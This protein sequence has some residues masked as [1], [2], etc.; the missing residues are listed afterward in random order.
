MAAYRFLDN[1]RVT[2]KALM[3][4][5]KDQCELR[6]KGREIL[7]LCDTSAINVESR[8]NRIEDASGLGPIEKTPN[9]TTLGFFIHPVLAIDKHDNTVYGIAAM[10]IWNRAE[11][12][13]RS[14]KFRYKSQ[15][16][17]IEIKESMK[18]LRPCQQS[19]NSSLSKAKHV[20]YVMDREGDIIEVF[21]R[22][23]NEKVDLVVRCR[24]NRIIK[25]TNNEKEK[26]F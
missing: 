24:H 1:A 26:L 8:Y 2:E 13:R 15:K 7:A 23:P 5:L 21:D 4:Q 3:D 19:I 14:R 20:T 18:W 6:V 17:V 11:T 22:L 10:D 12:P 16:D 9:H 25:N